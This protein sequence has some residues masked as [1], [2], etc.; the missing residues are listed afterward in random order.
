[1]TVVVNGLSR[2][3]ALVTLT[4]SPSGSHPPAVTCHAQRREHDAAI[5]GLQTACIAG[6]P[7]TAGYSVVNGAQLGPGQSWQ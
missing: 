5:P 6:S 3:L 7:S 4:S 1:M 2:R